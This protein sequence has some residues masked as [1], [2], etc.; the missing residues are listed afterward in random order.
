M[1]VYQVQSKDTLYG[2]A[3]RYLIRSGN[4]KVLQR[5]D[6]VAQPRS[7][8]AFA[9]LYIAGQLLKRT[10]LTVRVLTVT[11]VA[12]RYEGGSYNERPVRKMPG[13]PIEDA[14]ARAPR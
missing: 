13:M 7:P 5:V 3:E 10:P 2:I 14:I 11:G 6:R 1:E 9:A 8:R 12:N 4:W